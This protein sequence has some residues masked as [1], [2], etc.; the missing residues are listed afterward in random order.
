MYENTM[1]KSLTVYNLIY[2]NK[3]SKKRASNLNRHFLK[4]EQIVQERAGNALK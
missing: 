4:E 2:T 3:N 1:M